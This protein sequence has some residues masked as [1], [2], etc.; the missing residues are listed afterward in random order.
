MTTS[1]ANSIDEKLKLSRL[2]K[3]H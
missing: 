3:N 2:Q 1:Y